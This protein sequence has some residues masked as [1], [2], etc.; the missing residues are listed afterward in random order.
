MSGNY[1][2]N[3]PQ[4]PYDGQSGDYPPQQPYAGQPMGYPPQQQGSYQSQQP[5][6]GQPGGY[7][8]QQPY[9][10]AYQPQQQPYGQPPIQN[11][12]QAKN[13]MGNAGRG[14]LNIIAFMLFGRGGIR[15]IIS[16]IILVLFVGGA[17][18]YGTGI[19]SNVAAPDYPAAKKTSLT[20]TGKT[21]AQSFYSKGS[22]DN[23]DQKVFVTNDDSSKI[24]DFYTTK[25][26]ASGWTIKAD[27]TGTDPDQTQVKDVTY[28]KNGK[29]IM[30]ATGPTSL[31]LV[32]DTSAGTTFV[33]LQNATATS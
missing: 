6:T 1:N 9:T 23:S 26:A 28:I 18:L 3:Q 21:F 33:L 29:L 8:P 17:I 5:Y 32:N 27:A 13:G 15:S 22:P 31:N 19:L 30:L 2:P 16:I 7:P 12:K 20:A 24:I 14:I 4:Q 10:G 25:L 11:G